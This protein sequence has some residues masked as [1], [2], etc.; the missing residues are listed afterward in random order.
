MLYTHVIYKHCST[1][2]KK[3]VG[4]NSKGIDVFKVEN[5]HF[6]EKLL[7]FCHFHRL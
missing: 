7:F 1:F 2:K 5:F 3:H 4:Q 6:L